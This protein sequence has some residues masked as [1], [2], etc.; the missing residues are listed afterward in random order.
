MARRKLSEE[1]IQTALH[2][3]AG[4]EVKGG[5]LH[6]TFRFTSFAQAIGWMVSVAVYADKKDH[7]PEWCNV[8]NRVT[9]DL[10]TH[11]LDN[12]ISNLDLDLAREMDTLSGQ[13]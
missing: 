4:W 8:Y 12:A 10:A 7:H 9:V 6:K 13:K 11:D 2:D 5:K 3:L 1:E